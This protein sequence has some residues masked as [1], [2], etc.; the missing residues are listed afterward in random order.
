[1][2]KPRSPHRART[3]PAALAALACLAAAGPMLGASAVEAETGKTR[4]SAPE[5]A[6][7]QSA[8]LPDLVARLLPSVVSIT[9][10]QGGK[11]ASGRPAPEG[12]PFEEYFREYFNKRRNRQR[13][14]NVGSGFIVSA[15]GFVVTNNHVISRATVVHVVLEADGSS[16]RGSS[17]APPGP[18]WRCSRSS[19]RP[20]CPS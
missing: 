13:G 14:S 9:T 16:R 11:P 4:A 6:A 17:A 1:M 7:V 18:T 2:K 20:R 5:T 19:P 8:S 10:T 12:S 15:D 3:V